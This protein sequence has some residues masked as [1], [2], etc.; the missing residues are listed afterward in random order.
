[1]C[2]AKPLPLSRRPVSRVGT[3]NAARKIPPSWPS[4]ARLI[5]EIDARTCSGAA[6]FKG[7]DIRERDE[8]VEEGR[9]ARRRRRAK[10][11]KRKSDERERERRRERRRQNVRKRRKP[12]G[13]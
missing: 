1:M 10:E 2:S 9:Q 8:I 11:K 12:E 4:C 13:P 5:A 3:G 7:A 6:M